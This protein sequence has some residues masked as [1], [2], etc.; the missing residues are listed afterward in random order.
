MY[1]SLKFNRKKYKKETKFEHQAAVDHDKV[2]VSLYTAF[3]VFPELLFSVLI[4][5]SS[6]SM[7]V[8]LYRHKQW[9]QH[10]LRTHVS[11]RRSVESR[12]TQNILVLV[13]TF[14]AFY[15][16]SAILHDCTTLLYSNNP[17]LV[18]ITTLITLCFPTMSFFILKRQ[19]STVSRPCFIFI[20]DTKFPMSLWPCKLQVFHN[21]LQITQNG[22]GVKSLV[23]PR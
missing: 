9:V 19:N 4:T 20:K 16:C 18:N 7:I 14:L 12:V 5:S 13:S 23:F 1:V 8:D 21:I 2:T 17:W 22:L 10:I 6:R 15:T 3:F 11:H